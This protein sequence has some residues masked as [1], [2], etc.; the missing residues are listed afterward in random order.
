MMVETIEKEEAEKALK[1]TNK[2]KGKTATTWST[3]VQSITD[4]Q[5]EEAKKT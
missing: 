1:K 2:G 5:K 3:I 4:T